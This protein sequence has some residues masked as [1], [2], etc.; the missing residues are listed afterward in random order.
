MTKTTNSSQSSKQD[1][2]IEPPLVI[3]FVKL[4]AQSHLSENEQ[5]LIKR[6]LLENREMFTNVLQLLLQWAEQAKQTIDI[7]ASSLKKLEKD[8]TKEVRS[9]DGIAKVL[10]KEF[11]ELLQF[12]LEEY[13]VDAMHSKTLIGKEFIMVKRIADVLFEAK[14]KQ[15]NDVIIHLEFEREYE[16]D[17]KM[18]KRKLEYRHLMEMDDGLEGKTILCNVFYLTGSPQDKQAIE[19]RH[20]KLPTADPRYSGELR[21]KAYHVSSMTVELILERNLPFLLPFIVKS[22]LE[23]AEVSSPNVPPHVFSIRQQIDDN[24]AGLSSMIE[25]L[26]EEQV[27]ILR[28]TVEYLWAKSYSKD[29]FNKSTLLK[30]MREQLD[31]RQSDIQSGIN[32]GK[33]I[34]I[35]SERASL[36]TAAEK[37]V[38]KGKMTQEQVQELFANFMEEVNQNQEKK[39]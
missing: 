13:K 9:F 8:E 14:D 39:E 18:D 4:L 32:E 10:S 1:S 31:L 24:Q 23:E 16:S 20:I 2:F 35:A 30:L 12:I 5:G 38:Q 17:G 15:G 21:Y 34:A 33:K 26:T 3:D 22:E 29:V 19:E 37:M 7:E 6:R 36:K 27:E 11:P 25:G 28:V